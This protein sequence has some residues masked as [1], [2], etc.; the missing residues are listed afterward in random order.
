M[1][2]A[3]VLRVLLLTA[4]EGSFI[5]LEDL[6]RK[7]AI[8]K[9]YEARDTCLKHKAVA[10]TAGVI[11]PRTPPSPRSPTRSKPTSDHRREPRSRQG[12]G[13]NPARHRVPGP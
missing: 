4:R 1:R 2:R 6:G 5:R 7:V 3:F 8:D 9:S 10:A 13:I 12:D 11:W